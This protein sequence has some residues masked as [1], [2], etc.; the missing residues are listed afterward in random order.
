MRPCPDRIR[1]ERLILRR[2]TEEDIA[3]YAALQADP[4]VRRYFPGTM[5]TE[6]GEADGRLHAAG[7]E[8]HGF[9]QWVVEL[10]GVSAFIGIAGLRRIQREMPFEPRVDVGWHFLP[11]YWGKGYATE[12]GRAALHDVFSRTDL[13]QVV[14]YTARLNEPS[15][16]VMRRLGMTHD[17]AEDFD[18]PSV[19]EDNPLRRHVL[20]R[21]SRHAFGMATPS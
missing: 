5:P 15:R 14:A 20:Y 16:S 18:H 4:D 7:F 17:P 13:P 8:R 21:I 2:W 12:A 19:P 10:P 6:K 9:D 1:T 11:A 3:R